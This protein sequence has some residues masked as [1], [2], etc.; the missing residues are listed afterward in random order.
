MDKNKQMEI[1]KANPKEFE[2]RR[3]MLR[4]ANLLVCETARIGLLIGN[5]FNSKK[6]EWVAH[7]K[8]SKC[9][10]A[11]YEL[12]KIATA[13]SFHLNSFDEGKKAWRLEFN[14]KQNRFEFDP[15]YVESDHPEFDEET[16]VYMKVV[17][18]EGAL[19][20]S[21]RIIKTQHRLNFEK[22][23]YFREFLIDF[24]REWLEK[25]GAIKAQNDCR[26]LLPD[27]KTPK[28]TPSKTPSKLKTIKQPVMPPTSRR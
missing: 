12:K 8:L 26:E 1:R 20:K 18:T 28:K 19:H 11:K 23:G 22:G 24:D 17:L 7:V 16:I 4:E 21:D 3:K 9:Y 6:D 15:G 27:I 5:S 25:H 14:K 2:T 13:S 10:E